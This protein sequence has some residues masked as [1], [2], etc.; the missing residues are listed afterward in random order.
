MNASRKIIL[1]FAGI[2]LVSTAIASTWFT[3]HAVNCD[4][5]IFGI[6]DL[7][8]RT[9]PE[10]RSRLRRPWQPCFGLCKEPFL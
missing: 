10:W 7:L 6:E 9:H 5:P 8:N 3:I 1:S 2:V 4:V